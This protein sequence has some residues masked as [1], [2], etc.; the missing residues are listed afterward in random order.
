[1]PDSKKIILL[2]DDKASSRL[3]SM[4]LESKGYEVQESREG[5]FAIEMALRDTPDLM[6]VDVLLPDMH[7]S[8]AVKKLTAT[9]RMHDLKVLFLTSLLSKST[10]AGK[11]TRLK[12][13]GKE[14]P[15]LSKP[16]KPASLE[17]VVAEMLA[18]DN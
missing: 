1:M 5:R 6:I 12:V 17:K 9:D 16:F 7:G 10:E 13:G 11:V 3:L 8:E 18:G 14:Y 4:F 2:E 15:A